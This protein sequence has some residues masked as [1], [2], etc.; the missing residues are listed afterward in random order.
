MGHCY[1]HFSRYRQSLGL[2]EPVG[3]SEEDL[4][5]EPVNFLLS[6]AFPGEKSPLLGQVLVSVR[7]TPGPWD[8]AQAARNLARAAFPGIW[9]SDG[10]GCLL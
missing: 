6:S 10:P 7:A 9:Y 3:D 8:A 4:A 5:Y 1:E 2:R